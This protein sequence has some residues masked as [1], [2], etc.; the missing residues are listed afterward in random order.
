SLG[1]WIVR[2]VG[3]LGGVG[4]AVGFLQRLGDLLRRAGGGRVLLHC[5]LVGGLPAPHLLLSFLHCFLPLR[6]LVSGF[7]G[8]LCCP[9]GVVLVEIVLR[10]LHVLGAVGDLFRGLRLGLAQ[11]LGQVGG[12]RREPLLLFGELFVGVGV[13]LGLVRVCLSVLGELLLLLGQLVQ[14]LA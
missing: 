2:F 12:L 14:L 13:G 1:G 5:G 9:L 4:C 6:G 7:P 8:F 10:R 11:L 3:L